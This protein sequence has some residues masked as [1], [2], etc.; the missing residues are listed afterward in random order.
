MRELG[1]TPGSSI[2]SLLLLGYRVLCFSVQQI[3]QLSSVR[4]VW[5]VLETW[6]GERKRS[7]EIFLLSKSNQSTAGISLGNKHSMFSV[8]IE[9]GVAWRRLQLQGVNFAFCFSVC[10]LFC[11]YLFYLPAPG[12]SCSMRGLLWHVGSFVAGMWDLISWPWIEPVSPALQG[13]FFTTAPPG[14]SP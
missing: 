5:D 13:I 14:K 1:W 2:S 6:L 7:K 12:P 9:G 11:I 10:V 4:H 3:S 8:I